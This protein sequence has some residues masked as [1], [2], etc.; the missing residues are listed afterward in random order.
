MMQENQAGRNFMNANKA[1]VP[2]LPFL[3]SSLLTARK[4]RK[5]A[6]EE[7]GMEEE[8]YEP[9]EGEEVGPPPKQVSHAA[10]MELA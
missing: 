6:L 4:P 5:A 8:V 10:N 2:P 9:Q 7:E 1:K 3:L